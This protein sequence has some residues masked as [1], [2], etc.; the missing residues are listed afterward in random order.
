MNEK[1]KIAFMDVAQRFAECSTANR[2]KVGCI[3]VKDNRIISI[4]Y[5]GQPS[6]W[7]N[8]CEDE[9]NVTL[10]TVI[11]AESNMLMKLARSTE[12]G[13]NGEV[14]ITHSPCL[15]CSKLIAISGIKKVYYKNE[16]RSLQGI[17][18]LKKCNIE[19]EKIN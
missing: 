2:L 13:E 3:C 1:H 16:Y 17:E 18:F 9:N 8:V 11:H 19:I 4:G 10:Q 15:E 6:G 5:N 7:D 12:S 14:F